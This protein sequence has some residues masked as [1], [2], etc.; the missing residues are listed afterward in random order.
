MDNTKF[1][2]KLDFPVSN[3]TVTPNNKK[4]KQGVIFIMM[5]QKMIQNNQVIR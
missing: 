5:K 1:T 2:E 4:N 3:D